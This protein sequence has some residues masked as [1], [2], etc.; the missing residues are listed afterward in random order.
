MKPERLASLDAFRGATVAGMILVNNPGSWSHV[1]PPLA[2]AAWHGWTCADCIFPFFLWIV[3]VS[4]AF[5][6]AART[7]RG[8][9]RPRLVLVVL[10]RSV[11]LF[12]LGIFLSGFPFGLLWQ[13]SF[14]LATI[15]IPGVLQRIA[16][17]Y[18]LAAIVALF[19]RQRGQLVAIG[20]L[21]VSYWLMMQFFPVPEI[22]AGY[23]EKGQNFAAYVDSLV[24]RGHMWSAT[25]T[26]DPEG[27]ISTLPAIATTLLGVLTGEYLLQSTSSKEEKSVW[28]FVAGAGFL[29]LGTVLDPV[30]PINKSLWTVSYAVFMHGWALCVLSV[31][32]FLLDAKGHKK[33][34]YPWIVFGRNAILVFVLAGG[35]GRIM[36]LGK[37]NVALPD[38]T[39]ESVVLKAFVFQ[40]YFAPFFSPRNASLLH[41][42]AWVG[43]MYLVAW[44]MYKKG[45]FLK[46]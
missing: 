42:I 46:V 6:L 36:G 18:C 43:I 17:C 2:H 12:A 31:F 1:Y 28:M 41:A 37:I 35:A 8:A 34:A 33:W 29:V 40:Q 24:L 10:R 32:Y 4:L 27:I 3:G 26:W 23:Y 38:G 30:M 14:S 21:C 19:T 39:S 16:V 20:V 7:F 13:H 15:R 22:G 5:S 45:V 25:K 44:V 9:T 11:L